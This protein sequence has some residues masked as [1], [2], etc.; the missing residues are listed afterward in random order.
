MNITTGKIRKAQRVVLYGPEGI[1]KTTFGSQFPK[2][3]F[4]DVEGGTEHIDLARTDRPLSWTALIEQVKELSMMKELK[5]IVIDTADWAENL[6]V[7]HI[8]AANQKTDI[9]HFDYGRGYALAK[10]EFGRLLNLLNDVR[11]MG[12]HVVLLAHATIRKFEQPDEI[13]AYDRWELKMSKQVSPLVKEW[14]DMVL[15]ANYET[16]V[17]TDDKTKSKKA[18]G[19]RRVMHTL[20][21]PAWDAKN[22]HGLTPKIDFNFEAIAHC[23]ALDETP[24]NTD[25]Q[26]V[27]LRPP[28]SAT[29]TPEVR[30]PTG[31]EIG[32]V[33]DTEI[34]DLNKEWGPSLRELAEG[35]SV[36]ALQI[37]QAV[38]KKGYFPFQM[39]INDYPDDFVAGG[40]IAN[41]DSVL[42]T[43]KTME[44]ET[45]NQ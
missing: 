33:K 2:P 24:E 19:G 32:A 29:A 22:R 12:I 15:F 44:F 7:Q 42:D 28:E 35:A 34:Y 38:A 8:C 43:I 14:A 10:E 30:Q 6:C 26:N 41:W 3:V 25:R 27:T 20:H 4:I 17:V 13:G 9:A 40:L 16:F 11:E 37:R 45:I 21:G 1:G 23:L 39:P 5:T 18:Q 36:S 31:D